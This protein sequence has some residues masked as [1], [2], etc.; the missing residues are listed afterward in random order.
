[1]FF[2]P[3]NGINGILVIKLINSTIES[4]LGPVFHK[5][6]DDNPSLE[7]RGTVHFNS[8]AILSRS[9]LG[10]VRVIRDFIEGPSLLHPMIQERI[11][12][13]TISPSVSISRLWLENV[14]TTCLTFSSKSGNVRVHGQKVTFDAGEYV[15]TAHYIYP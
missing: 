5:R 13:E 9:I 2:E 15:F 11:R 3:D 7:V 12:I 10:S 8:T 14:T 6:D 1:M 4:P